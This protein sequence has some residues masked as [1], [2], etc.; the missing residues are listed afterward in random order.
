MR[1]V[2]CLELNE[3]NLD[4]A[5]YYFAR[6][7]LKTL[8]DIVKK[9]GICETVSEQHYDHL[10]PWIQWVTAHT[11]LSFEQ[12]GVF[13]LGDAV[14]RNLTQIWEM[15]HS[16]GL[17]VGAVS[18]MNAENHEG[19]F[20]FFIPDPWTPTFATAPPL[21]ERLYKAVAQA[22][23]DNAQDKVN[24]SS[25]MWLIGG[26]L[27][28]A[29]PENYGIYINL[30]RRAR[31]EK[32][33]KAIFLDLLLSDL[34]IHLNLKHRPDFSSL[35]LNAAAHIQ[36]HYMFS[37]AAYEGDQINPGW[38]ISPSAD[39]VF[40]IYDLYDKILEKM[41]KKFPDHRVI[42]TTGLHQDPYPKTTYYWRLK[43]H[44]S[45][46]KKIG[47]S[48]D[49]VEPRMSRDFFIKCKNKK[50]A[51][52][53]EQKLSSAISNDGFLL[54]EVDNRGDELFVMLVY[55]DDIGPGFQFSIDNVRYDDLHKD[56]AFVAI[57]N[58]Q[59]NGTGY[60]VDC[61][62]EKTSNREIFPLTETPKKIM[63]AMGL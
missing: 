9:H 56:V 5:E 50:D 32:W 3:V 29:R 55:P 25:A 46:L 4:S 14:G 33:T 13:R 59:H 20:E 63:E 36:H 44:S 22:V 48:F 7:D 15:L 45:F 24:A 26:L 57:K 35:F 61:G 51:L 58:G 6:G 34:F 41:K 42:I 60:F 49:F 12:H 18:P 21:A 47:A 62:K 30:A 11:G 10:E 1:N 28:Y 38:Y 40:E 27:R 54:F 43:N 17:K 23:N 16:K 53:T 19:Q 37:S 39:P 52:E 8:A 2:I 31:R